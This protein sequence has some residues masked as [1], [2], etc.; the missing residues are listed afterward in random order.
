MKLFKKILLY[1]SAFIPM[2]FLIL[3]K[4]TFGIIGKSIELDIICVLNLTV[5]TILILGGIVGILWNTVWNKENSQEIY[6]VSKNNLTDQHF[7]G[8]F[9]IFVLFALAFELTNLSMVIVSFI[10]IIFVGVVYINN[11]MFYI[12][13][14]LNVLGFNFYEIKYKKTDSEKELPL[15]MFYRGKLEIEKDYFLKKENSNFAFVDKKRKQN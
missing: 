12:N 3:V 7:F 8:Y 14:L 10:I 11:E 2:Y 13:P 6:I 15:K 4:F 9:S 1:F 5:Y